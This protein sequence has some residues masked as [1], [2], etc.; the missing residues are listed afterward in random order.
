MRAA[1]M[2]FST[3]PAVKYSLDRSSALA[4]RVGTGRFSLRGSITRRCA[5]I[6]VS[7]V[8]SKR[9]TGLYTFYGQFTSLQVRAIKGFMGRIEPPGLMKIIKVLRAIKGFMG[10]IEP[11]G[12]MK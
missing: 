1:F 8:S 6:D 7:P 12:L 11:P 10:R 2:S 9:L 3:S 4:G 5:A